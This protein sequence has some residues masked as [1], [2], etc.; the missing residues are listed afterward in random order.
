MNRTIVDLIKP[1]KTQPKLVPIKLKYCLQDSP[2]KD[3]SVGNYGSFLR[4]SKTVSRLANLHAGGS[5]HGFGADEADLILVDDCV[6]LGEWND[7]VVEA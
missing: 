1:V 2:L 6:F 4:G 3:F 7:G 5:Y